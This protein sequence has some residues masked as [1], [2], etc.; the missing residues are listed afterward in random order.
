MGTSLETC[1]VYRRPIFFSETP[2]VI[3]KSGTKLDK[4]VLSNKPELNQID[5]KQFHMMLS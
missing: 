5:H 1:F 3:E 2:T 4:S